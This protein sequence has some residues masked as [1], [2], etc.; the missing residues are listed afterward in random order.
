MNDLPLKIAK[1][2]PIEVNNPKVPY[3]CGRKVIRSRRT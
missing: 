2:N 1:I 3:A